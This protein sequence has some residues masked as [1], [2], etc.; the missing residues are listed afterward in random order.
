[1]PFGNDWF[2]DW[3]RYADHENLNNGEPE[4]EKQNSKNN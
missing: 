4:I 3:L 2:E 1:M